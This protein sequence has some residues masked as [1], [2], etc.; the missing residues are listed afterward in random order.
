MKTKSK[1]VNIIT[2]G[3]PK[4]L[5]DSEIMIKQLEANNF[6]VTYEGECSSDSVVIINT[7]GFVKDAKQESINTILEFVSLK[8][9]GKIN[10]LIVSGCLSE[11]YK[12][13]LEKTI[14]EVDKYFGTHELSSLLKSLGANY[15]KELIGER[16]ITTPKHYAYLKISEGCDRICSF[17][18][19]PQIR[20]KHISVRMNELVRQTKVLAESG[21]KE[22][23]LIAQDLTYY[24]IDIYGKRKLAELLM[25][26]SEINGIEWIRL[27]YA[28]P[29]G[30][31]KDALCVIRTNKKICKYLDIPLQHIND[32]ILHS[33]KRGANRKKTE[34]L[35]KKIRDKIPGIAIRTSFIC[36]YPGET[37][38]EFEELFE[39]TANMKFER[40]GV[41][42]YS[43]EEGTAAFKYKDNVPI[44]IKRKRMEKIMNLQ[45]KISLEINKRKVNSIMKIL[46]DRCDGD[47]I[48]GRTEFDSPDIDNEVIIYS[49]KPEKF[50]GKFVEV[51]IT[52]VM[53]YD[54]TGEIVNEY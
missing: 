9:E 7:C 38:E 13:E 16:R 37:E 50:V 47:K 18:A 6:S 22:I 14:P 25:R 48:I 4:N 28:Y 46:V 21:V 33:M 51:K 44:Q 12:T 3:C 34:E 32:R 2:L 5:F 43:H 1:N 39:W 26:L 11:R 41:F 53:E 10:K 29:N 15:K 19:I 40:L 54:L 30:F 31:P 23:I 49:Q 8:N 36:G 27:H 24:G 17:C 45:R 42:L 52:G 35:I 20:G